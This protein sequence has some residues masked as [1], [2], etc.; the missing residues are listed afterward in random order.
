MQLSDLPSRFPI[1]FGNNAGASYIRAIPTDA[2]TPTPTDAPASLHDGFPPETFQPEGSGGIPPNGKDVN[3]ILYRLSA[4]ARWV[5]AGGAA[6]FNSAFSSAAGGYP[7][8]AILASTTP[9]VLWQSTA[10]SN[11]TDPDGGSAANWIPLTPT[12]QFK[13][14]IV[15]AT[16]TAGPVYAVNFDAPFPTACTSVN[17]VGIN[18]NASG[19]RD[20]FIQIVS[21]SSSGFSYVVQATQTGGSNTLDGIS[22][23]AWGR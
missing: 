5:A 3:G 6:V 13:D 11:M 23:Q 20:N 9:G 16:L 21:I 12:R 1:P 15:S 4:W 22:W 18:G 19:A 7:R 2:Q 8:F 10:D 14:G 17:A